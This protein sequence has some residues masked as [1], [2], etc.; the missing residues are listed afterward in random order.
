MPQLWMYAGSEAVKMATEDRF[1]IT[2][3]FKLMMRWLTTK[4]PYR[5]QQIQT[6]RYRPPPRAA[7]AINQAPYCTI[8]TT[9]IGH[10]NA[11]CQYMDADKR[12]QIQT[13]TTLGAAITGPM[14]TSQSWEILNLFDLHM[15]EDPLLRVQMY[16]QDRN[17][18]QRCYLRDRYLL[19]LHPRIRKRN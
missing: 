16:L 18:N 12:H 1:D 11:Q 5:L 10:L 19:P 14:I 17:W 7:P 13:P 8:K 2:E 15:I 9:P 4:L 6:S 3:W